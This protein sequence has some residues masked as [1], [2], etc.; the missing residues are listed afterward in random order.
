MLSSKK[1]AFDE[2]GFGVAQIQGIKFGRRVWG[3]IISWS[4][5]PISEVDIGSIWERQEQHDTMWQSVRNKNCLVVAKIT[6]L[7]QVEIYWDNTKFGQRC[8]IQRTGTKFG[9]ISELEFAS[10]RPC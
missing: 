7:G 3:K 8:D 9:A 5:C 2:R 1:I 6:I 10:I 4:L